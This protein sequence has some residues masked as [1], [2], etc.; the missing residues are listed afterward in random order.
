MNISVKNLNGSGKQFSNPQCC[1]SWIDHWNTNRYPDG[2]KTAGFCRGCKV[3]T[4]E[5]NGGHVIKV[6][7]YDEKRYIIPLCNKCN[8][9][10]DAVFIVDDSDLVSANCDNCVNNQ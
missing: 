9:D 4:N 10:Y 8:H 3:K 7:S 1:N 2:S 6:G 5:L